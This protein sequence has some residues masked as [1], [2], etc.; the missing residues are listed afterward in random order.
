VGGGLKSEVRHFIFERIISVENLL[1]AWREFKRGKA[2]KQDVQA[3]GFN[4]EDNIFNL[5]EELK[6][7]TYRP[8]PYEAFYVRDPK[9][10]CIHKAQVRDRV[11]HQAIFRVLYHFFD[12][13]FIY[14]SYSCRFN[15]GTQKGVKR[16]DQFIRQVSRNHSRSVYVLK[17]D[18]R[19]FFDSIDQEILFHLIRREIKDEWALGL[20]K[21]VIGSFT[22]SPGRGLPL[23]NVT[24]QLFANIYLDRFD[25]FVK[26]QLKQ[27]YYLRYCD[28][29]LIVGRKAEDLA[30]LISPL[31]HFLGTDL[32]LELHPRKISI[33]SVTQGIDWLGYVC[34]PYF[35]VL[36]TKTKRRLL[37]KIEPKNLQSYLGILSHCRG[38]K[39]A[40]KIK[41]ICDIDRLGH[42]Q[43]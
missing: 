13:H 19:K 28:D 24:S 27:K 29:F 12:Q 26:H 2:K 5:Y 6:N 22:K 1:N 11:L 30:G 42:H 43:L 34:L 3:F 4:L 39:I 7:A 37:A 9:L 10:R 25:Q 33:R 31:N 32:K 20:I 14:D 16:L 40:Q 21:Q 18:V 35:R 17:C 8:G 23:G 38:W 41:A 36:R 15:K